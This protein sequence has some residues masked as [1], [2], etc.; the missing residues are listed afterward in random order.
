MGG[1]F[2]YQLCDCKCH[3]DTVIEYYK[4]PQSPDLPA[5]DIKVIEPIVEMVNMAGQTGRV[6]D[7]QA[8]ALRLTGVETFSSPFVFS[9]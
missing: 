9:I 7:N 3:R 2:L 1:F 8:V 4:D 6:L 5:A